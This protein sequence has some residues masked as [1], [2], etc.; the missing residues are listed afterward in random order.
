M[1]TV[2][3]TSPS[4][5]FASTSG[6]CLYAAACSTTSGFQIS[7]TCRIRAASATSTSNGTHGV[8]VPSART[9]RSIWYS[10][11]SL[12]ST[13]RM[14][15]GPAAT[16]WRTSSLPIDPPAPVTSTVRFR[17]SSTDASAFGR[18]SGRFSNSD[19]SRARATM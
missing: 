8:L 12:L 14:R 6:T 2:L 15:F 3:L 7:N 5:G 4:R 13:M 17:S 9:S 18:R 16:A 11:N 1:A 19:C 10:A